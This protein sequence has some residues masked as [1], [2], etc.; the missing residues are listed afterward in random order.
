MRVTYSAVIHDKRSTHENEIPF[1]TRSE[2]GS[3]SIKSLFRC[4]TL[5]DMADLSCVTWQFIEDWSLILIQYQQF[6]R[7]CSSK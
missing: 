2:A 6:H 4:E 1:G 3:V 7:R 5:T